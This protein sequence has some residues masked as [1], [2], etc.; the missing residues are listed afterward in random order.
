LGATELGESKV[1]MLSTLGAV[2]DSAVADLAAMLLIS[3]SISSDLSGSTFVIASQSF[4]VGSLA[5]I[6]STR[7][8]GYLSLP[9][10]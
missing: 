7:G 9:R 3:V 8:N 10:V 5:A 4:P 6:A 2:S 1:L